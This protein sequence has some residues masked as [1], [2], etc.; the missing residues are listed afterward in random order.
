MIYNPDQLINFVLVLFLRG[1]QIQPVEEFLI[2]FPRMTSCVLVLVW[3]NSPFLLKVPKY[4]LGQIIRNS[5]PYTKK[6]RLVESATPGSRGAS[7]TPVPPTLSSPLPPDR[8]PCPRRPQRFPRR[9]SF[10]RRRPWS[11]P[12]V[13]G[14]AACHRPRRRGSERRRRLR[15]NRRLTRPYGL[16]KNY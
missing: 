8:R 15:F 12:C 11:R 7:A 6:F 2:V 9:R 13:C 14:A 4:G 5:A 3:A 10:R 16:D 1:H